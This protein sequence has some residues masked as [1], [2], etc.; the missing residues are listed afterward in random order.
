MRSQGCETKHS[1]KST[2]APQKVCM[3]AYALT[4]PELTPGNATN[5]ELA[6]ARGGIGE[7]ACDDRRAVRS[8]GERL[9]LAFRHEE[10]GSD[11]PTTFGIKPIAEIEPAH[12]ARTR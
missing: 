4:D 5:T 7:R 9:A 3:A 11:A 1:R 10:A 8:R 6:R 12:D 2:L